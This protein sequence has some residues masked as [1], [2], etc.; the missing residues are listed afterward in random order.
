M[1]VLQRR[2]QVQ[3]PELSR[4]VLVPR[5]IPKSGPR[6][7]RVSGTDQ[8]VDGLHAGPDLV[9]QVPCSL[10]REISHLRLLR[11]C[12]STHRATASSR[13]NVTRSRSE[14]PRKSAAFSSSV[15]EKSR[16]PF[17]RA[18]IEAWPSPSASPRS[19]W[20]KPRSESLERMCQMSCVCLVMRLVFA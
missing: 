15:N 17:M 2:T 6:P 8:V 10:L 16:W 3:T 14:M 20:V 4:D 5:A 18:E 13:S 1:P 11:R 9:G 12:S 19:R 7:S